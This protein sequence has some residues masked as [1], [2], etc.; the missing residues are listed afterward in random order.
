[1]VASGGFTLD[2]LIELQEQLFIPMSD[3]QKF[4]ACYECAIE[5]PTH[6]DIEPTGVGAEEERVANQQ[7][8]ANPV[9]VPLSDESDADTDLERI[10][11]GTNVSV[12]Q[13]L[14]VYQLHPPGLTCSDLFAHMIAY[15]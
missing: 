13:G 8:A 1:M 14:N 5:D 7:A 15:I 11:V 10:I 6:L 4:R 3:M 9:Q 12:V 2:C